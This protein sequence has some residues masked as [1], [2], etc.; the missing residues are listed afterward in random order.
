MEGRFSDLAAFKSGTISIGIAAHRSVTL[1]PPVVKAFKKL[2]PGITL[3]IV[4][5]C[6]SELLEAAAHGEFDLVITTLPVDTALFDCE[7]I[8]IEENI[9]ASRE[10]L[11][12][13]DIEG[14][15]FPTVSAAELNGMAFA[16]LNDDH[17]MQRELEELIRAHE[18][19][20]KKSVECTSL[21]ALLEM[22]KEG[23]GAAFIPESLAK[24]Q[25][26]RYYSIK[27]YVPRR[28]IV[29]MY[30]KEQFLSKAVADLK[31]LIHE[32]LGRD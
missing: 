18:L 2:Y 25:S 31:D 17:L 9:V 4:E 10:E 19:H 13:E 26:L 14:R 12:A 27:E 6:R 20:L 3:L 23:I 11:K 32:V 5:R 24:D 22:A 29:V 15:R 16:M 21:E 7:L 28:E 8:F 1:M 30:R